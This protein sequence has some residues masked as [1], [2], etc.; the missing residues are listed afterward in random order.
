MELRP[1]RACNSRL[2]VKQQVNDIGL[3][4]VIISSRHR[5]CRTPS[6][7][8]SVPPVR[9]RT[10]PELA[11]QHACDVNRVIAKMVQSNIAFRAPRSVGAGVQKAIPMISRPNFA[12]SQPATSSRSTD[13]GGFFS[14]LARYKWPILLLSLAGL[15]LAALL[16]SI[17]PPMYTATGEVFVDPRSRKIVTDDVVQGGLGADASLVESQVA[18]IASD[19]V[20]R[21]VV[22]A[23]NLAED[24]EF[25]PPVREGLLSKIKDMI[26]GPR[27]VAEP[28]A[29][30]LENLARSTRVSRAA[31]SYV[32]EVGVVSNSPAKSARLVNSIL[33][34]YTADQ[35]AAKTEEAKRANQLIDGRLGELREQL[36]RAE[37]R[38]DEFKKANKILTSEGGLVTEQQLGKLNSELATARAVAA[39]AKARFEQVAAATRQGGDPS[40]LPEVVKSSLVQKL[41][42]QFAQVS[43]REAALSTQLQGRHPVLIEVRSQLKELQTQI[44]A[45]VRRIASG[46]KGEETIALSREREIVR[47]IE[48]AKEE[49]ARTNTAQ[50]KL[51]ELEQEVTTSR[52]LL[53][54]F[55]ARA[56]ETLEQAN[57]STPESRVIT[58]A[59]IPTKPS[60]S[61]PLLLLTL[62]LL[63]GLGL[64]IA[65]A[66]IGDSLDPNLRHA[67]DITSASGMASVGDLPTIGGSKPVNWLKSRLSRSDAGVP[68]AMGFSDVLRAMNDTTGT[69]APEYRQAILRLL[70]LVRTDAQPGRSHICMV[71]SPTSGAGSSST[72]LALAYSAATAG[73]RVLLIDATSIDA[74]L[75][76]VF[77]RD[78]EQGSVIVLDNRDDLARITTRDFRSGLS[79]LPIALTDLRTLK[80]TQRRRLLAGLGALSQSY[81][82]VFIDAGALLE[83]EA[84]ASLLPI[85]DQVLVVARSGIATSQQIAETQRVL[86]PVAS[87]V[88]GLVMNMTGRAVS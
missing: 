44:N 32:L 66:L 59:R 63:G 9:N 17:T 70:N 68:G 47:A 18:I 61:S 42:E 23:E 34:A 1:T 67:Q 54:A 81:D 35:T 21:R 79:F 73:E 75:S 13:L 51:R 11:P 76:G 33:A 48:K 25:A 56:K 7:E 29:L 55:L 50:I 46:A 78:L 64:G 86:A 4:S 5:L 15:G 45:E 3:S 31:K 24:P 84:A 71:V 77:A 65:R 43:R 88:S 83:D 10:I 74:D 14:I 41:R 19:G 80:S 28:T 52:E 39:E 72:A 69:F 8:L 85:A 20:L 60:S 49:I 37:T 30:A 26:R 40:T 38:V 62:G 16:V 57:L 53:G 36:R 27:P 58:P 22:E 6:A 82:L 2:H 87:Q 12:A